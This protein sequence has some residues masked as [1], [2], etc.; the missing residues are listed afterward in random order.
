MTLDV[1][2]QIWSQLDGP[3]QIVVVLLGLVLLISIVEGC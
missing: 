2:I 3:A 1:L